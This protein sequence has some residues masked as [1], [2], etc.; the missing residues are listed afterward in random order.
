MQRM[1]HIL[2][3][4][5]NH[6]RKLMVFLS[7]E[8][9]N[10]EA[11]ARKMRSNI[12]PH[13][14][15][16]EQCDLVLFGACFFLFLLYVI[17]HGMLRFASWPPTAW[18]SAKYFL[19]LNGLKVNPYMSTMWQMVRLNLQMRCSSFKWNTEWNDFFCT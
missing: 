13:N 10:S 7:E 8:R 11:N 2:R 17:V 12:C 4:H 19:A 5:V 1:F 15:D 16:I 3:S 6:W 9:A 18:I 14:H